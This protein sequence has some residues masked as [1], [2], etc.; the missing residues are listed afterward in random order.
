MEYFYED[1]VCALFKSC[2]VRSCVLFAA[3]SKRFRL[4]FQWW[5]PRTGLG[6]CKECYNW[7]KYKN[8]L[9]LAD[10]LRVASVCPCGKIGWGQHSECPCWVGCYCCER[11]LPATLCVQSIDDEAPPQIPM[12]SY[13]CIMPC[14]IECEVCGVFATE[15]TIEW[16]SISIRSVDRE[17]LEHWKCG[18]ICHLC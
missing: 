14:C 4:I 5:L 9:S 1:L 2:D 6:T 17:P 12:G 16:F 18:F 7:K 10:G 8:D 15:Y 13:C 3:T 11:K